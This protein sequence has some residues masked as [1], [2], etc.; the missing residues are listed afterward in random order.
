MTF[1]RE[2][3]EKEKWFLLKASV[4]IF[5]IFIFSKIILEPLGARI[6]QF[7]SKVDEL[8]RH[9]YSNSWLEDQ[10]NGLQ[11]KLALLEILERALAN[12]F[13]KADAQ[14]Y[15]LNS[16]RKMAENEGLSVQ[17]LKESVSDISNMKEKNIIM[18][19]SGSYD[20]FEKFLIKIQKTT[21]AAYVTQYD[22]RVGD[23]EVKL[24]PFQIT[25]Y[26]KN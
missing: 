4:P 9:T 15:S 7:Q 20:S 13:T 25:Y 10:N 5:L 19:F 8:S 3:W 16:Y 2:Y 1:I 22:I 18:S 12:N 21:P 14:E 26:I 23:G 6:T 17:S 11:H 24:N